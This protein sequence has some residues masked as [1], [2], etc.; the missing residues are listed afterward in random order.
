MESHPESPTGDYLTCSDTEQA[1]VKSAHKQFC[2]KVLASCSPAKQGLWK[3]TLLEQIGNS[4]QAVWGS[5]YEAIKMEQDL[6]LDKDHSSFN[7]GKMMV[8]TDQLLQIK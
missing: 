5:V 4:H 2:K 7:V 6:T 8:Q 3:D 1:S